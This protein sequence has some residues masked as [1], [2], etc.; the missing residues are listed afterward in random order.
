MNTSQ[1]V[2]PSVKR[3]RLSLNPLAAGTLFTVNFHFLTY[4]QLFLFIS[5]FDRKQQNPHL[6]VHRDDDNDDDGD[7]RFVL[8]ALACTLFVNDFS[9]N[10]NREVICVNQRR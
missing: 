7:G 2:L 4:S 1:V 3:G 6:W 8:N 9:G 10:Y 5:S